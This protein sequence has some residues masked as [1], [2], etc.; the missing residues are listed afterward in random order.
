MGLRP[1]TDATLKLLMRKPPK[2]AQEILP[3]Y[4]EY[5]MEEKLALERQHKYLMDL[6]QGGL[7]GERLFTARMLILCGFPINERKPAIEPD[8]LDSVRRKAQLADRS[9]LHVTF[10]Q[11]HPK[12]PLPFRGDRKLAYFLTNKAV[13]QQ[14]PI[15]RWEYA[16]EYMRLFDMDPNSG[17]NY[18]DV[19]ASFTRIAYMD[20]L[21]EV[22]SPEG[23]TVDHWKCPLI[24]HARI[25]ADIDSE[26]NWKPSQ[27]VAAMLAAQQSVAF[28]LRFFTELQENPVPIPIELILG[29]GK[30]Y[31]LLDYMIF[32]YW[33]AW[34]GQTSS[35]IP[36]RYLQDQFDKADG[37]PWRWPENFKKAYHIMKALPE[38]INQIRADI[39]SAGITIHPFATG[40]T[41]FEGHPKMAFRKDLAPPDSNS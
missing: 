4:S 9:W 39:T 32:L 1:R 36:W 27:S 41:F 34:A 15:L 19:Q 30:K 5:Q 7:S 31:R 25:A 23:K 37:N 22:I 24:D 12:I 33:R 18:H 3:G 28:G 29:A 11:T 6:W 16:N 40:T 26:G 13:L 8:K 20:I 38:P 10:I 14:S 35:F 21:V 17:K 2:N